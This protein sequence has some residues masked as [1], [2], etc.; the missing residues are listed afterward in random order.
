MKK[1]SVM[2]LLAG[3]LLFLT[4]GTTSLSAQMKCG[5]GK[6]GAAMAQPALKK[7][8]CCL[9]KVTGKECTCPRQVQCTC[10]D[11]K[12]CTCATGKNA[13]QSTMKCGAGK[14]GAAMMQPNLKKPACCEGAAVG[15]K[16]EC[17]EDAKCSCKDKNN[18][19]CG[20]KQAP[21]ASMKCGTGK[22]G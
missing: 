7:P 12:N 22:C 8:A 9:A 16:C 4:L 1:F 2:A 20:V 17:P 10:E 14:C 3:A 15:K 19:T 18:C 5:A 11:E 6:C 13:A 21:K